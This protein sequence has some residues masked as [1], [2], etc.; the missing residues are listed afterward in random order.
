MTYSFTARYTTVCDDCRG[1]IQPGEEASFNVAQE[2][3]HVVCPPGV[4][5]LRAGETV[6]TTC[7]LVHPAGACDR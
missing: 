1:L 2:V 7:W 5:D 3:V 4:D 6:C